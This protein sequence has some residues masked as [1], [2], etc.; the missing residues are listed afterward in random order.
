MTSQLVALAQLVL[1]NLGN[2][3]RE[4]RAAQQPVLVVELSRVNTKE[5]QDDLS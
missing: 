2:R 1:Y 4:W 5:L 3:W